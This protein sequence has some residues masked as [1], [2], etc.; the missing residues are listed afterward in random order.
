MERMLAI[1]DVK[2]VLHA[3]LGVIIYIAIPIAILFT[4]SDSWNIY[5]LVGYF[6]VVMGID[7]WWWNRNGKPSY[8]LFRPNSYHAFRSPL[9]FIPA[10]LF[11]GWLFWNT[12]APWTSIP[13]AAV[14]IFYLWW[15]HLRPGT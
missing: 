8:S 13:I 6:S 5:F 10:F 11:C 2:T 15:E 9:V 12:I 3:L 7:L 1:L 4:V 14:A